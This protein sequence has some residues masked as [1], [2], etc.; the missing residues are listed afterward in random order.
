MKE[1]AKVFET[2]IRKPVCVPTRFEQGGRT[3]TVHVKE[4]VKDR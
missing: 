2:V 3:I 1:A 4:W